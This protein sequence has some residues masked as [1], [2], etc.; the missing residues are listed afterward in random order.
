[1]RFLRFD[2]KEGVDWLKTNFAL[3]HSVSIL[4]KWSGHIKCLPE[5]KFFFSKQIFTAV[6][7]NQG[8]KGTPLF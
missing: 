7:G 5:D 6:M 3:C 4:R 1:M 8:N 2:K